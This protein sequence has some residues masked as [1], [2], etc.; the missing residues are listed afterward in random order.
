MFVNSYA[1]G[2][3]MEVRLEDIYLEDLLVR[4]G[5]VVHVAAAE[6]E[7]YYISGKVAGP[8]EKQFRRGISLSQAIVAGGGRLKTSKSCIV[9]R[10]GADGRLV[11]LRVDLRHLASGV[12]ADPPLQPGDRVEVF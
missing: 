8:G 6:P 12:V 5:D 9:S 3:A 4:P 2:R 7:F 11:T 1:S 10:A